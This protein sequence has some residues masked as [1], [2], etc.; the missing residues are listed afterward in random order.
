LEEEKYI[1]FILH[2]ILIEDTPHINKE[3]IAFHE[4]SIVVRRISIYH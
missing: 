4:L 1:N 3:I 2:Y